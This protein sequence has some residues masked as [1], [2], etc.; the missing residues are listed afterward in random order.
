[1]TI[2]QYF[3]FPQQLTYVKKNNWSFYNRT[4]PKSNLNSGSSP[5]ACLRAKEFSRETILAPSLRQNFRSP[6]LKF[7]IC[8]KIGSRLLDSR[9]YVEKYQRKRVSCYCYQKLRQTNFFKKNFG[10]CSEIGWFKVRNSTLKT[11]TLRQS[12]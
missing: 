4:L 10:K 3:T 6:P 11:L 12:P 2:N 9:Y 7:S 8:C 5:Q 1:M